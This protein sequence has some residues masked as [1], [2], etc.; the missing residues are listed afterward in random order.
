M[1][2]TQFNE[3]LTILG[4]TKRW[5]ALS[6][7]C[8][9]NLATWWSRGTKPIPEPIAEALEAMVSFHMQRWPPAG[10]RRNRQ[11]QAAQDMAHAAPKTDAL[12]E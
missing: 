5:L 7:R 10:W 9:T 6:L 11:W 3:C 12:A 8:D 1:T 4:W 2:P